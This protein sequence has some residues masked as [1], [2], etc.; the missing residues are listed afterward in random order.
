MSVA[1][2][3]RVLQPD[4]TVSGRPLTKKQQIF[5]FLKASDVHLSP[6]I[7]AL[8]TRI[9]IGTV[10]SALRRM[11]QA[12][13][14]LQDETGYFVAKN[15]FE[16]QLLKRLYIDGQRESLPKVHDIHLVFKV[17]NLKQVLSRPELAE[18][19][20]S[21][22]RNIMVDRGP[23]HTEQLNDLI[24]GC[25]DVPSLSLADLREQVLNPRSSSSVHQL[26]K[27]SIRSWHRIKDIK[28]G[29]QEVISF[30]SWKLIVQ[31]YTNTGTIK[32]IFSNSSHP[33]DAI[34]VRTAISETNGVFKAR[35]GIQFT[36]LAP[37]FYIEKIHIGSDVLKDREFSGAARF[38]CTIKQFDGW[39]FRTYE[40][41]L[42]GQLYV[43]ME[44]CREGGNFVDD[45]INALMAVV[46]GQTTPTHADLMIHDHEKRLKA[47]E[48]EIDRL[49]RE[50]CKE[51]AF[52]EAIVDSGILASNSQGGNPF[53]KH[54]TN[55]GDKKEIVRDESS[56]VCQSINGPIC[57]GK[58]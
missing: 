49:D 54:P 53:R 51:K 56:F 11:A 21:S 41:V 14:V 2:D 28:G 40:K 30:E 48:G 38:S 4:A 20:R 17:E 34:G 39:L 16:Q 27:G 1:A 8:R 36:E 10:K 12:N 58:E 6:S 26:W 23:D 31:I 55:I 35:T 29:F 43:R 47:A 5:D 25:T 9:S 44:E 52:R 24:P 50:Q 7:I 57:K 3:H 13:E 37:I 18:D 15:E 19:L 22:F 46:E 45:H 42:G 33:F 32:V